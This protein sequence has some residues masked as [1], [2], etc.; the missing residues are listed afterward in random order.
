LQLK[1]NSQYPLYDPAFERDSCGTG[2][3]VDVAGKRSHEILKD[4]I[5]SVIN[6]THRGAVSADAKTGD[7]AGIL[8][9]LPH[10]I[11]RREIER[12]GKKLAKDE[13]LAVGMIFF[14]K[15][16]F[17]GAR[18]KGRTIVEEVT[19]RNGLDILGWRNVPVNDSV[20]GDQ[21][22]HTQPDIEQIM[23][24]RGSKV[25][26]EDFERILYLVRRE[27]EQRAERD[28]IDGFYI[29]SFSSKTIVY[30]GLFVATQLDKFYED[31]SNPF[32]ETALA[33]FHQ[34]YSTNTFPNWYLAQPFRLLGHNGEINTLQGNK[35]WT[36]AREAAL[37]SPVWGK[38]IA[39]LVPVIQPGG[40]DSAAL[41]NV[42]ELYYQ[43]GRDLLHSVMMMVPEA[44]EKA[45]SIDA[46]VKAF[47]EYHSCFSEPWDGP[48]AL[49]FSDGR[50]VGAALDRNGL[51]PAR[52]VVTKD[53]R[54]IMGSEVGLIEIDD[55]N[56]VEKGRL[57]PGTMIAIDT[58]EGK[59]YKNDEIKARYAQRKPYGEW[60]KAHAVS[61]ESLAAGRIAGG[62]EVK[63]ADLTQLRVAFN[64]TQEDLAMVLQPMGRDG[65]EPVG[66][67][68]DDTPLSILSIK[69][70]LLYTYFRQLFAQVTNPPIDHLRESLV[71]SLTTSLGPQKNILE[72][73]PEH[74]KM[75]RLSSH[76]LSEHELE[77]LRRLDQDPFRAITLS[78][79]FDVSE[80]TSPKPSG[81]HAEAPADASTSASSVLGTRLEEGVL[82]LCEEAERAVLAGKSV[83]I[84]SDKGV[85][86]KNAQ[87]PML[88]AVGAVQNHL[89]VKGLRMRC[90]IVVETAE[91]REV[92]HMATLIGYGATAICPY[93]ALETVREL[94]VTG[95][96]PN[97]TPEGAVANYKKALLDGQLKIMSKMGIS[98]IASYR[99]AQIFEAVGV[100][101]T[102]IDHA[103]GGT[104][105]RIGG[106][107]YTEIAADVAAFHHQ[108][109]KPSEAKPLELVEAGVY[110]YRSVGEFHAFNPE[111]VKTLHAYVK[112]GKLDEYVR[113]ADAV[114]H[115]QPTAIRDL[116]RFRK[117]DNTIPIDGVES[118]VE[119]RK[120]F[121]M[122]G[123]SH[124]AL[125]REAHE[126]LSIA[127]NRIG[128]K[129]SS[130]E[131]GEDPS[132]Y[133]L[134]PNGDDPHSKIKQIASGRFGVTV[135][136]LVQ[137]DEFEI[138]MAQGAKPGEGGQLPGHK[139]SEEIARIRHS[140]P[141]VTLISPP[142]HHDIYSIEDLSQLIY[143]L[144]R[145]NPGAKVC[146]KLVSESGVGTVAAGCVKAHADIVLISG[147]DGGTGASPL[148]SIKYAGS[149]WEIGLAEAQQVLVLNNLR[150]KVKLRADG[151]LKTGRDI[152]IAA[153]LGAEEY[154]FGT[155]A[156][157]AVGCV[158]VRQCHLNTC[159]VG[160]ATQDPKLR[161]K[162][163]GTP[164]QFVNYLTG[165]AEEVRWILADLG[166]K[167]LD[168]AIGR[169][170]LLEI[171]YPESHPKANLIDFTDILAQVD[172]NGSKPKRCVVDRNDWP[173]DKPLDD[174]VWAKAVP[175][176]DKKENATLE[177]KIRNVD[178]TVGARLSGE[179]AK[180]YALRGLPGHA[181][182]CR[183]SGSAGQSF[184][185][186]LAKGLR[187]TIVGECND[188][189]GKGLSGGEIVVR[190][191]EG[192]SFEPSENSIIGNTVMYGATDGRLYAAGRAG[193]RFCVRNSGGTA[194]VEG[195]GD[196][197]CEYMT[198]GI[199]VVLGTTGKNFAAGMTG[200]MAYTLDLDGKFDSRLNKELVRTERPLI[201]EDE[202]KVRSLIETHVRLTGSAL[203]KKVLGE[204]AKYLPLLVKVS[205]K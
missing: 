28:N 48:A 15:Q 183:F 66:S 147:H 114:N 126:A 169:V 170:D 90:N 188:Y 124:G 185:A 24:K 106:I 203:G 18:E 162:F 91:A 53:G 171:L 129:G 101:R 142:P 47:Y 107:G 88:L 205:P 172:P 123:I 190:P 29:P 117:I 12:L 150:G 60:V 127:M 27:I 116:F 197:G 163:T 140:V 196:H 82:H 135:E 79:L 30:K 63:E 201:P 7:G 51:R 202:H 158:M 39:S 137:C 38:K 4:A 72:E 59:I 77:T 41:D 5:R 138:K 52:Y 89:I 191:N 14:P 132:R 22:L 26:P 76:V 115:R 83:L 10:K 204:W 58:V 33:V 148:S 43:S 134:L 85:D 119:I 1:K 146:V 100:S 178:R 177:F 16:G 155:A 173:N 161:A 93:L 80:D 31:L 164:D 180:R 46:D 143:D 159:P 35:N 151:G 2:F 92:H 121:R 144:K 192:V 176:L 73:T 95:K 120:R 112:S 194:V 182:E 17:Y 45:S 36:K 141:G 165:V 67:M 153:I 21:A 11:F 186:F 68:G 152:V 174:D 111:V 64:Y 154:G 87:I 184:G 6:L 200:G 139:V 57:G 122:S 189:V 145:V 160:V 105:S 149:P 54:V 75:M 20:L 108:A 70:R 187:F 55:M 81:T 133:K 102:L 168:E 110:R 99:G 74:A 136:Y 62:A 166:L 103:F 156:V 56:V 179:V 34:R 13:D 104:S 86:A 65:K 130:G 157:V 8:T 125:S 94:A 78:A 199:V 49:T 69:P 71:F 61:F 19:L 3:I 98:C 32:F 128:G 23:V 167:N 195:V 97:Q 84:L 25:K 193:E 175:F 37:Q 118:A 50:M 96:I 181:V 40:S 109:F 131:G 44:W 9:Q 42:M 113:F 198:G